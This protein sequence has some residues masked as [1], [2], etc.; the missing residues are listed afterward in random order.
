MPMDIFVSITKKNISMRFYMEVIYR[1][2][3]ALHSENSPS[4]PL[5][6]GDLISEKYFELISPDALFLSRLLLRICNSKCIRVA[7]IA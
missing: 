4:I 2:R 6:V 3:D 5:K 1:N 7:A